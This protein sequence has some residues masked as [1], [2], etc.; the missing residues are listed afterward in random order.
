MNGEKVLTGSELN[1]LLISAENLGI[2]IPTDINGI[3]PSHVEKARANK[4]WVNI[5][6]YLKAEID[7]FVTTHKYVESL[8]EVK[9]LGDIDKTLFI[10]LK[11]MQNKLASGKVFHTFME[12]FIRIEKV[13]GLLG[14]KI[15]DFHTVSSAVKY[16]LPK[17]ATSFNVKTEYDKLIVEYPMLSMLN[18]Y[19]HNFDVKEANLIVSYVNLVDS[20]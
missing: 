11:K 14:D 16:E 15:G 10:P 3:R 4:K 8:E 9:T 2:K 17:L 7:K 19:R 18:P 5:F 1:N 13:Y 12:N 6:D 20:K